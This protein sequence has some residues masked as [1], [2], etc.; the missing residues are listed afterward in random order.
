MSLAFY[1][2]GRLACRFIKFQCVREVV[3]HAERAD[4]PGGVLLACTHLS[5]LEP[6]VIACALRRNVRWMARIEFYQKRWG[7]AMLDKGGAFPVDR[8]GFGLPAVRAGIRLVRQGELVGVFPEGGVAQGT[9]SMLRGGPIRQGVC[10]ISLRTGVPIVPVVV[11]GT[12]KL[13][14]VGPWLPVRRARLYM[15]FGR[16]VAPP[17]NPLRGAAVN[18]SNRRHLADRLRA[19]VEATY[20]ELLEHTGLRDADVP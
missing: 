19:E 6:I 5:H 3:L 11:L 8:F 13:N 10:T 9:D 4:R 16:D 17:A 15:A 14:R 18:R 12:E 1:K 7:A 2:A 20:R